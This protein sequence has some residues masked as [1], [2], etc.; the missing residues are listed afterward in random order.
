MKS[1]SDTI[2]DEVGVTVSRSDVLG[3]ML[4]YAEKGEFGVAAGL[5]PADEQLIINPAKD[6]EYAETLALWQHPLSVLGSM[7]VGPEGTL[8]PKGLDY[9]RDRDIVITKGTAAAFQFKPDVIIEE[10]V[11]Y[12][13]KTGEVTT[14]DTPKK[15]VVMGGI[16]P[17]AVGAILAP[18][19]A[20]A[21]DAELK[22]F[23]D[24]PAKYIFENRPDVYTTKGQAADAAGEIPAYMTYS[25]KVD[26]GYVVM[27]GIV[28]ETKY[29][30]SRGVMPILN[31]FKAGGQ[32]AT[33]DSEG[34]YKI[35]EYTVL[36]RTIGGLMEQVQHSFDQVFDE[37][38]QMG[39]GG[40]KTWQ[41]GEHKARPWDSYAIIDSETGDVVVTDAE[42]RA[43]TD[44]DWAGGKMDVLQKEMTQPEEGQEWQGHGQ[45][46]FSRIESNPVGFIAE[47]PAEAALF[48]IPVPLRVPLIA[49]LKIGAAATSGAAKTL[50]K[51]GGFTTE[52]AIK[53]QRL[54]KIT[55]SVRHQ[56][57]YI[58]MPEG[59]QQK[60]FQVARVT[61]DVVQ[62]K[63]R[64]V[65]YAN[66]SF[67]AGKSIVKSNFQKAVSAQWD[68]VPQSVKDVVRPVVAKVNVMGGLEESKIAQK[69]GK[70]IKIVGTKEKDYVPE[71]PRSGAEASKLIDVRPTKI[72]KDQVGVQMKDGKPVRTDIT[73]EV[74]S[75]DLAFKQLG[76]VPITGKKTLPTGIDF[77]SYGAPGGEAVLTPTAKSFLTLTGDDLA[78]SPMSTSLSANIKRALP[79][80]TGITKYEQ[81][82]WGGAPGSAARQDVRLGVKEMTLGARFD[83]VG[84]YGVYAQSA[85]IESVE[86]L[87]KN[88]WGTR[89]AIAKLDKGIFKTETKKKR[90]EAL[91]KEEK[92]L[93][94]QW[95]DVVGVRQ[96]SIEP[97][98][99]GVGEWVTYGAQRGIR[100]TSQEFD[101]LGIEMFVTKE[102]IGKSYK[103]DVKVY[104]F[105][106][107][108]T[109][110]KEGATG[111]RELV[112]QPGWITKDMAKEIKKTGKLTLPAPTGKSSSFQVKVDKSLFESGRVVIQPVEKLSAQEHGM[113]MQILRTEMLELKP[114]QKLAV[115]S[116]RRTGGKIEDIPDI[117]LRRW[118][119]T[120]D[121]GTTTFVKH[122]ADLTV[123]IKKYTQMSPAQF[124]A[125]T[126][127][128]MLKK[129]LKSLHKI[130]GIKKAK[131]EDAFDEIARRFGKLD[132]GKFKEEMMA[133]S[134]SP[135]PP[136]VMTSGLELSSIVKRMF[137]QSLKEKK[138]TPRLWLREGGTDLM[139]DFQKEYAEQLFHKSFTKQPFFTEKRGALQEFYDAIDMGVP[140]KQA[141]ADT[142]PNLKTIAVML[143]E[144]V[145]DRFGRRISTKTRVATDEKKI[146]KTIYTTEP[147]EEV[148][149]IIGGKKEVLHAR[150]PGQEFKTPEYGS[151]YSYQIQSTLKE[152]PLTSVVLTEKQLK[153]YQQFRTFY[154]LFGDASTPRMLENVAKT[155]AKMNKGLRDIE[156]VHA[157]LLT[158]MDAKANIQ[159]I[160]KIGRGLEPDS[161]T[162]IIP[163][164]TRF[165]KDHSDLNTKRAELD[166][167]EK[168]LSDT[169]QTIRAI[170]SEIDENI[171]ATAQLETKLKFRIDVGDGKFE[172]RT[173]SVRP[174][175]HKGSYTIDE[176]GFAT[177][178]AR[179]EKGKIVYEPEYT[180]TKPPPKGP[181]WTEPK[182]AAEQ[183]VDDINKRIKQL[184]D[185]VA[186]IKEG[187][188][189][190]LELVLQ[191]NN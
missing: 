38:L 134:P 58:P 99:T 109:V 90:I 167:A 133:P 121:M 125:E 67:D 160:L 48:V 131:K 110:T 94:K 44:L 178:N 50:L 65:L 76:A 150:I 54:Q 148:S 157:E 7:Y 123:Q 92:A 6:E 130:V 15:S 33:G 183:R 102:R 152:Q 26:A 127:Q 169:S 11:I 77:Y 154:S 164:L 126:L 61:P 34:D 81:A 155:E 36:E 37:N 170:H 112:G 87:I 43:R 80:E 14:F 185:K 175:Q 135:A 29:N 140:I 24:A 2:G 151:D 143:K 28:D 145:S 136:P 100:I 181:T 9:L 124:Q 184:R 60:L 56:S 70:G 96:V 162:D 78:R 177:M 117:D 10:G 144:G 40:K 49:G 146:E 35:S 161:R 98:L 120:G 189:S 179:I 22:K 132:M 113:F 4:G 63:A 86:Q 114:T 97:G 72:D 71:V 173:V 174:Q 108:P 23:D 139:T 17:F 74:A 73:L 180:I 20:M 88:V 165:I 69:I 21:Q 47:L 163:S 25:E 66:I 27:D 83:E 149:M 156:D 95:K 18:T 51:A 168:N 89:S 79:S 187:E 176:Q 191:K 153:Q 3:T 186:V 64:D 31:I 188:K 13:W 12:P 84:F 116:F 62:A 111:W 8:T 39:T 105:G 85:K 93:L 32:V 45:A 137:V 55:D 138:E 5:Q 103:K 118:L 57:S 59:V 122:E 128:S 42:Q 172:E 182:S 141:V 52:T 129:N 53:V 75:E 106:D 19:L 159:E 115:E 91:K 119:Q 107:K 68:K 101:E 41:E 190:Y 30:L 142:P 46:I 82:L 16:P 158:A 147:E 104:T 171:V 1:P 166:T